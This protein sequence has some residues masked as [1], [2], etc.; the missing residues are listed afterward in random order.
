MLV[1]AERKSVH[2][3]FFTKAGLL[4]ILVMWGLAKNFQPLWTG[5]GLQYYRSFTFISLLFDTSDTCCF[6]SYVNL[7]SS[8]T[9]S[10]LILD[11][12]RDNSWIYN[13]QHICC[14]YEY[15]CIEHLCNHI[16]DIESTFKY[17]TLC[18][19]AQSFCIL[20]FKST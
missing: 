15:L 9:F 20:N 1:F 7:H 17:S 2:F 14:T 4:S 19:T 12:W 16:Y 10:S 13:F 6:M 18:H 5:V 3:Y 8:H 11:S